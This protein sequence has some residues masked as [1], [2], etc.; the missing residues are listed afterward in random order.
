MADAAAAVVA[1]AGEVDVLAVGEGKE[2]V[3]AGS[4]WFPK[5]L[6]NIQFKLYFSKFEIISVFIIE[7]FI[8]ML[9]FCDKYWCYET[10]MFG[11]V[12]HARRR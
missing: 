3:V 10:I 12:R 2:E 11:P 5:Y 8:N 4:S 1:A 7:K 6:E 9:V